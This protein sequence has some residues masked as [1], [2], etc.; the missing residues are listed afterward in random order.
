MLNLS[1]Q[2]LRTNS[3]FGQQTEIA[4]RST[5]SWKPTLQSTTTRS[6]AMAKGSFRLIVFFPSGHANGFQKMDHKLRQKG[7]KLSRGRHENCFKWS[8][9]TSRQTKTLRKFLRH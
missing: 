8:L 1:G 6:A 4:Q 3:R 5:L 9:S 2:K 7:A